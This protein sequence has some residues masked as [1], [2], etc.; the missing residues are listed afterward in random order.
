MAP[1]ESSSHV[2]KKRMQREVHQARGMRP[3]ALWLEA[4]VQPAM[5]GKG[6]TGNK[7]RDDTCRGIRYRNA[8]GVA[9]KDD[10]AVSNTSKRQA[11]GCG[12]SE[13]D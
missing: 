5:P 6:I 10:V 13:I 7:Y 11:I 4:N 12:K 2:D 1:T 8:A 9:D 3:N